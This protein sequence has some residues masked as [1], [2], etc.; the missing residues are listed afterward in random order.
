MFFNELV[1]SGGRAIL[2][3]IYIK[4]NIFYYNTNILCERQSR[5]EKDQHDCIVFI[6]SSHSLD[7]FRQTGENVPFISMVAYRVGVGKIK[8]AVIIR[9][10]LKQIC[11]EIDR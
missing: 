3:A 9:N 7:G 5:I 11:L 6:Y 1:I 8:R 10:N 2:S 4:Y